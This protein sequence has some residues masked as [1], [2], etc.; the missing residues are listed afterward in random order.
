MDLISGQTYTVKL[1]QVTNA[2]KYPDG[3]PAPYTLAVSL[4][5]LSGSAPII[6]TQKQS[7]A[8]GPGETRSI[9]N[10][11][12]FAFSVAT[13]SGYSSATFV[14][15]LL[16]ANNNVLAQG[17]LDISIISPS[18][19]PW[20][21]DVNKNGI[22]DGN[23]LDQAA[24]DQSRGLITQAQF[25]AVLA[26]TWTS[27]IIGKT[28]M[29]YM[30]QHYDAR[31][32]AVGYPFYTNYAPAGLIGDFVWGAAT[33]NGQYPHDTYFY[34]PDCIFTHTNEAATGEAYNIWLTQRKVAIYNPANVQQKLYVS[35][36]DFTIYADWQHGWRPDMS[37]YTAAQWAI[38]S[39]WLWPPSV[40]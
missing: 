25:N 3:T 40:E 35:Y 10:G 11:N 14:A 5:L 16:D 1:S 24:Y 19:D 15:K 13:P 31:G 8:F 30:V 28:T 33:N 17:S 27:S 37:V 29:I 18:F 7:Y 34:N 36:A 23:E 4:D 12:P 21:Y 20:I 39:A 22:I 2:S 38:V 26:L 6:T 9:A 32:T